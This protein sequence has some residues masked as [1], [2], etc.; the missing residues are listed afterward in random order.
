MKYG[1]FTPLA[2]RLI[3]IDSNAA[4]QSKAVYTARRQPTRSAIARTQY[5]HSKGTDSW[6]PSMTLEEKRAFDD[7]RFPKLTF[8]ELNKLDHAAGQSYD[9]VFNVS[10][11]RAPSNND[12][13]VPCR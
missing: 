6:R 8:P 7:A 3:R 5:L 4:A 10:G 9:I 11:R 12:S 1:P 2:G 13:G